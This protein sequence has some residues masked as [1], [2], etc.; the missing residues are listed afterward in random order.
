MKPSNLQLKLTNFSIFW[1]GFE[2]SKISISSGNTSK[3]FTLEKMQLPPQLQRFHLTF[4][5]Q[6]SFFFLAP[7]SLACFTLCTLFA[8]RRKIQIQINRQ[9]K[10]LLQHVVIAEGHIDGI[11]MGSE[12]ADAGRRTRT[13]TKTQTR[14]IGQCQRH[15]TCSAKIIPERVHQRFQGAR[16]EIWERY[17]YGIINGERFS[18]YIVGLFVI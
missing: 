10:L 3:M 11:C 15:R 2:Q 12:D 16:K 13:K 7:L 9:G 18:G 8:I 6:F 17:I 1:W 5:F 14:P 4:S